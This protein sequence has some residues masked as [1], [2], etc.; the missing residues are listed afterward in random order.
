MQVLIYETFIKI[1]SRLPGA[2]LYEFDYQC[3][4]NRECQG[5]IFVFLGKYNLLI[6]RRSLLIFLFLILVM[7]IFAFQNSMVIQMKLWFWQLEV[8]LGI[9][10]ILFFSLGAI[11][12]IAASLPA[13]IEKNKQ[14]KD[15]NKKLSAGKPIDDP[16]MTVVSGDP[17]FEDIDE[18]SS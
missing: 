14:I 18:K 13:I 11:I 12:G 2:V 9:I 10:L 15:L 5:K 1:C 3:Y 4:N 8:H 7:T 6:L 16:P 17:E